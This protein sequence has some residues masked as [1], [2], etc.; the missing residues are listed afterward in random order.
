VHLLDVQIPTWNRLAQ[1]VS[2]ESLEVD[3]SNSYCPNGCCRNVEL[4]VWPL[5]RVSPK[6]IRVLELLQDGENEEDEYFTRKYWK[7]I[8]QEWIDTKRKQ[9][10]TLELNPEEDPW[11]HFKTGGQKPEQDEPEG[12]QDSVSVSWPASRT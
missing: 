3:Y 5:R 6:T 12:D 11:E 9:E 7:D 2:L 8:V 1:F 4:N 10:Y